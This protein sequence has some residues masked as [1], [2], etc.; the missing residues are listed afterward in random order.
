MLNLLDV[1]NFS[2][3]VAFL[4]NWPSL[5]LSL[6]AREGCYILNLQLSV[7]LKKRTEGID[8]R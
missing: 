4:S 6:L 7:F 1:E 2:N 5:M 8:K 3:S